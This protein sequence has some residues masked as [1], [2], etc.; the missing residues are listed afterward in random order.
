MPAVKP[1]L[2]KEQEAA[3][4]RIEA[5]KE[6]LRKAQLDGKEIE[7]KLQKKE[8]QRFLKIA[9]KTGILKVHSSD[10]ELTD[11]FSSFVEK[12]A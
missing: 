12:K 2:S 6:A 8:E 4:A 1:A 10:Q 3:N 7:Q 11:L 9:R 5:A